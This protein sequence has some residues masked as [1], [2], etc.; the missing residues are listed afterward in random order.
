VE[1]IVE[2]DEALM[3][4]YLEGKELPYDELLRVLRKATIAIDLIPVLC[5]AALK[6]KGVQMMLD[7]VVALLPGPL[8]VPGIIGHDPDD[9][10]TQIPIVTNDA[11]PL[12][13]LAFKIASDPFVGKLC[14]LRVYA[15][16]L[17]AGS[18]V[19]NASTGDKERIGRIVRLHANTRE[20]VD[21]VYAGEIAA[22]VGLKN[23]TTGNTLCDPSRPV[24]LESIVFP[25]P[26]IS[27][28]VEP[29]TKADQ[30]KMGIALNKLAEE[31]PTFRVWSDEETNQTLIAGM[32][33]LHL[34]IIVDR[35]KRE[36][37]VEVNVG[38]PQVSYRETIT[39]SAEGEGKFIR[40]SGGRGQYGHAV[41]TIEPNEAGKGYEF[42]DEIRGGSI[43]R[44][45]IE[46]INKG[47]QEASNGGVFAGYPLIDFKIHLIDGSFH[48][49]DS[50][51]MAFK[52]AGSMAFKS[53]AQKAGL[54][55]LE[56]IMKVEVVTPEDFMGDVIGDLSSKRG[57]INE[58]TERA[59]VKVI[60]A[61]VPLAE[62]FGYATTL[63][64]ISQG[65]ANHAMEFE[66]YAQ[67]PNN[68][69]QEI[70]EERGK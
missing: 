54:I 15:G 63:R 27:I 48:E 45:Y 64:S 41:V 7:Y 11:E 57:Q 5:G 36:F 35:M 38:K 69:A 53:A 46:P 28:A 31:D 4:M 51:E 6:N 68:I 61:S 3:A 52:V 44:E 43:P 12:A 14:F 8:D 60:R 59:G 42:L 16:T 30:E 2:N 37:S 25:E 55:L 67:V 62:M 18:Y 29:K 34:E 1:A 58:M 26:V 9:T 56:P 32:G 47:I 24:L 20:E 13:A 23:V 66:R 70:K 40:Q 49:V 39:K 50:N 21:A 10:E 19:L 65:R 17:K 22:A 33:E